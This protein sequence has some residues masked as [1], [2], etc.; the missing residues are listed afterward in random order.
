[1][2]PIAVGVGHPG[3]SGRRRV[4]LRRRRLGRRVLLLA[5]GLLRRRARGRG[6]QRVHRRVTPILGLV[7]A[8]TGV[9]VATRTVNY[10]GS[11]L[12]F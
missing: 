11:K 10:G 4:G 7:V 8:R 5:R 2:L 12:I 6:A 3:T 9:A 1:M